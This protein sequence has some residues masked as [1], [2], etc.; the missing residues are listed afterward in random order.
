MELKGTKAVL[1]LAIIQ[2][3]LNVILLITIPIL[4]AYVLV[5]TALIWLTFAGYKRG[6]RGWAIFALIYGTISLAMA[7]YNGNFL[8]IGVALMIVA[9]VTLVS[10]D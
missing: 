4:G 10:K 6:S 7:I 9:L 5:D 8:N 3:I 1:T 2:S